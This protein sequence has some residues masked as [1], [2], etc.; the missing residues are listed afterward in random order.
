MNSNNKFEKSN[1]AAL[2]L[3]ANK[4]LDQA[5]LDVANSDSPDL[6]R[7]ITIDLSVERT[8][9]N[10][11]K[12]NYPFQTVYIASA[13]D[14][15]T[16]CELIPNASVD[17]KTG[18]ILRNN[19][20]LRFDLPVLNF[21]IA[22]EAQ[23][24]KQITLF[25]FLYSNFEQ[26]STNIDVTSQARTINVAEQSIQDNERNVLLTST[27]TI[28]TNYLGTQS[29]AFSFATCVNNPQ[30]N[31]NQTFVGSFA[32]A[33]VF[34][35]PA[36][37]ELVVTGLRL[38]TLSPLTIGQPFFFIASSIA[39]KM[40]VFLGGEPNIKT[41]NVSALT[42][43]NRFRNVFFNTTLQTDVATVGRREYAG[44]FGEQKGTDILP[45]LTR[46]PLNEQ[47]VFPAGESVGFG[48]AGLSAMNA[49]DG[50]YDYSL[51]GYLREVSS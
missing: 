51:I 15:T 32:N 48:M 2:A 5:A 22:N 24:G 44:A 19:D 46:I 40:A 31:T 12:L 11:F 28:D 39:S 16:F 17:G 36:G 6:I 29:F 21:G 4:F 45:T 18:A 42:Y 33:P 26:G 49:P 25:F 23:P 47:A 27:T 3:Q 35:V 37:F 1:T 41:S 34:I 38:S 50:R 8:A 10:L 7:K 20:I 43:L 14:S 13:T 9:G 30:F